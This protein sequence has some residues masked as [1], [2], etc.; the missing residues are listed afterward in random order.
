MPT[1]INKILHFFRT[2]FFFFPLFTSPLAFAQSSSSADMSSTT[3]LHSWAGY[4]VGIDLGTQLGSSNQSLTVNDPQR[5]LSGQGAN[6]NQA[7]LLGNSVNS[8]KNSTIAGVHA[9]YL[10][11]QDSLV[12]GVA[13]KLM[14]VNCKTGSTTGSTLNDVTQN[15]PNYFSSIQGQSC[16]NYFSS[17]TGKIGK[18]IGNS[19]FYVDGGLAM[20]R[21]KYKTSAT[22]TNVG[23]PGPADVWTGSGSK[24]IVGYVVGAGIQYAFDKNV[25]IGLNLEHY[26]LGKL[27]Y[28]AQPDAFTA[29]DQP[30]VSQSM[31]ARVKGNLLRLS[32]DYQF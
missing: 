7:V 9:E 10:L 3:S 28:T 31:V 4:H 13:A 17:M 29:G 26:D 8:A 23:N 20:G 22:I 21:A 32:V 15:P 12:Y 30:G 18:A 11:Q 6:A 14:T 1:K 25:S 27:A 5:S 16:L 24:T 19:L 2:T